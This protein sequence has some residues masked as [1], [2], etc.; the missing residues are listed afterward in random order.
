ML[1]DLKRKRAMKFKWFLLCAM[2]FILFI[3]I[4]SAHIWYHEK[5]HAAIFDTY[6]VEYTHGWKFEGVAIAFYVEAQDT[7]N[8]DVVCMSLQMESEIYTYNLAYIYYGIW[9]I[10][11]IYLMKCFLQDVHDQLR[12]EEQC[13]TQLNQEIPR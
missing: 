11:F 4:D 13:Q 2:F 10:F 1:P 8:C 6:N 5:V 3:S 12:K 7:R 9:F